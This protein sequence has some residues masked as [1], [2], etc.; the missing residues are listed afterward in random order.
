MDPVFFKKSAKNGIFFYKYQY[1]N[2]RKNIHPCFKVDQCIWTNNSCNVRI[3]VASVCQNK[4]YPWR[5]SDACES[6][7]L[8]DHL[9][10]AFLKFCQSAKI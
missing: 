4:W 1:T 7:K 5:P 9:G 2:K 8:F 6:Q 3:D 10:S